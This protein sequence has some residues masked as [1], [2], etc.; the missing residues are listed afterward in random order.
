M[1]YKIKINNIKNGYNYVFTIL[2][3]V[4]FIVLGTIIPIMVAMLLDRVKSRNLI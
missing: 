2:Y 4:A 3:N 1:L